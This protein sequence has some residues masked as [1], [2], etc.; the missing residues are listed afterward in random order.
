M[1]I[2]INGMGHIYSHQCSN[3]NSSIALP[4]TAV[5][6]SVWHNG[7]S[8]QVYNGH[9]WEEVMGDTV[10]L[11]TSSVL[12][13]IVVWADRKMSEEARETELQEKFP[14]LKQ[15]KNNYDLIRKMVAE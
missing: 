13:A 4:D 14:A 11:A 5:P 15:A 2:S 1:I 7:H 10:N 3:Y 6:G 12:D 9:G 8:L